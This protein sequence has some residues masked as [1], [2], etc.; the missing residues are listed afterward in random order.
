MQST[1]TTRQDRPVL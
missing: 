1:T